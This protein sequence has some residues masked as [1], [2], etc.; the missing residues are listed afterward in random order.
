MKHFLFLLLFAFSGIFADG[1]TWSAD[2]LRICN[3]LIFKESDSLVFKNNTSNAIYLDS[4][5]VL[6]DEFD[7]SGMTPF[8]GIS[9][10]ELHW[11]ENSENNHGGDFGWIMEELDKNKYKLNKSYFYPV[12]SVPI[13]LIPGESCEI[14]QFKIGIH[15]VSEYP[16]QYPKYLH[17]ILRLFFSNA[18]F[19]DIII[20]TNDVRTPI[21]CASGPWQKNIISKRPAS[22]L[23]EIRQDGK[24]YR[25]FS[26]DSLG[27]MMAV[28]AYED[29]FSNESYNYDSLGQLSKRFFSGFEVT[30]Q[31]ANDG[32]LSS[33]TKYY[34][35]TDKT[36]SES[37]R[38][39]P[40]GAIIDALTF[41]NGDTTGYVLYRYDCAGNTIERSGYNKNGYLFDQERCIYDSL[42]NPTQLSFPFDMIQKGNII[43]YYYYS[44]IMSMSSI[45]YSS[46]F[47]YD[48][49]GLPLHE[50]RARLIAKDTLHF[51]YIY[52]KTTVG[53]IREFSKRQTA[54]ITFS[55]GASRSAPVV[56]V[57]INAAAL[58][59]IFLCD[60]SGRRVAM[61]LGPT[62][63]SAGIHRI[64]LSLNGNNIPRAG[65][66]FMCVVRVGGVVETFRIPVIRQ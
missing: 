13:S 4:A 27:R 6:M 48:A 10:F 65:G 42:V 54:T 44:V 52:D 31:Y 17:G 22:L 16:P 3:S 23:K 37:Y 20:Y 25:E 62:T 51:E 12:N 2:S 57:N 55:R 1:I 45:Q 18:Q 11:I 39:G 33:M 43:S 30:Y 47:E 66:I 38:R 29:T 21:L 32:S 35:V 49:S 40:N 15:L 7:T 26:Y 14:T 28:K 58:T 64:P 60:L 59:S 46:S 8:S 56:S 34:P 5:Y 9:N 36:W 24:P 19:V 50:T 63:F 41:Y 53:T 61:L